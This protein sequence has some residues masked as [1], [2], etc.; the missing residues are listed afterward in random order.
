M[1]DAG[2]ARCRKEGPPIILFLSSAASSCPAPSPQTRSLLCRGAFPHPSS[3]LCALKTAWRRWS[4]MPLIHQALA[5]HSGRSRITRIRNCAEVSKSL[6]QIEHMASSRR[7]DANA[8]TSW[9]DRFRGVFRSRAVGS[10]IC[11]KV[12][13]HWR[14]VI[15]RHLFGSLVQCRRELAASVRRHQPL[16]KELREV[17]RGRPLAG[18]VSDDKYGLQRHTDDM[19][20]PCQKAL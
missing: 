11:D 3:E 10:F 13:N 9:D 19:R 12:S 20:N 16:V 14:P 15:G 5:E 6:R 17:A 7:R 18:S 1:C 2:T 8:N 4:G